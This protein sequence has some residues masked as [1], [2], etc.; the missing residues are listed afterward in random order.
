[1]VTLGSMWTPV[2]RRTKRAEITA[3][4]IE[5]DFTQGEICELGK[6]AAG[7]L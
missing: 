2:K 1:M 6:E 7:E 3:A 5:S 4:H